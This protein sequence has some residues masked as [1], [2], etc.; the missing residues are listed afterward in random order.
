MP[1]I[2]TLN[3]IRVL[4]YFGDHPPPHFHAEYNEYE[5]VIT[6]DTL[7]VQHGSLPNKQRK[8]VLNW[9]NE[10]RELLNKKWLEFNP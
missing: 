5:I 7:E 9:A 4:M 3:S 2:A 6:I 1:T 8:T 10:N